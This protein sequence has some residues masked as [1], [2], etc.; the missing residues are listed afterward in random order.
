MDAAERRKQWVLQALDEYQPGLLRFAA[1]LLRDEDAARDA[2]QHAFLRLCSQTPQRLD[3]RVGPWLFAVCRNHAM[4]LA[5]RDSGESFSTASADFRFAAAVAA[6]GMVLRD[7]AHKGSASLAAVEEYAAGALGRD[8]NGHRAEF[9]DLVRR[10][11]E[12][13]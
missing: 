11:K 3:G 9:L 6:F 7:S 2:V 1:R 12:V 10:A 13:R 5:A 8:P 4:E